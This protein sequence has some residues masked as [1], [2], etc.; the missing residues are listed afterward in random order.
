MEN[1][2]L[3]TRTNK[4]RSVNFAAATLSIFVILIISIFTLPA[5]KVNAASPVYSNAATIETDIKA[6]LQ[7]AFENMSPSAEFI[8]DG[9]APAKKFFKTNQAGNIIHDPS[10]IATP[11]FGVLFEEQLIDMK[12]GNN[13]AYTR[14]A[15]QGYGIS[16]NMSFSENSGVINDI[17][18]TVKFTINWHDGTSSL[19]GRNQV[20]NHARAFLQSSAYTSKTTVYE[21]LKAINKYI[22]ETFQYDYRLFVEGSGSVIY[23]AYKMITDTGAINNYERGVCQAYSMYGFILLKEAGFN[24]ITIDGTSSGSAGN[25][26]HAWNLVQV[27]T[28]WYHIDFTW[29]DPI[30]LNNPEPYVKRQNGAGSVSEKYLLKSDTAISINHSWSHTKNGFTYPPAT[31]SWAGTPEIT[32]TSPPAPTSTKA[33]TPIRKATPTLIPTQKITSPA[34]SIPGASSY[35]SSSNWSSSAIS[36]AAPGESSAVPVESPAATSG[37]SNVT[38]NPSVTGQAA[39]SE[40]GPSITISDDQTVTI[41]GQ[42]FD[43]DGAILPG[44]RI[45]LFSTGLTT[46]TD[47]EGKYTFNG[48]KIGGYEMFL[49]NPDGTDIANLPIVISYG[50]TTKLSNNSILVKG[51]SLKLDLTLNGNVLSIRS[52]SSPSFQ[53]TFSVLIYT[54]IGILII[55]LII[56]LVLIKKSRHDY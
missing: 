53:I 24:A 48:V 49:K 35:W 31:S 19:S 27:G 46:V 12:P 26:P 36:S 41:S 17:T 56:I 47:S 7:T 45:E 22:C 37:Q 51:N 30:S 33:P 34:S 6:L 23:S 20:V 8:I 5:S 29:N 40:S 54:G 16:M 4:N 21:R 43:D 3:V 28:N 44:T 14:F 13:N 50:N 10:F 39:Q 38:G 55:L 25:G 9:V 2:I 32:V 11:L 15:M 52:I 18:I 42:L 1:K